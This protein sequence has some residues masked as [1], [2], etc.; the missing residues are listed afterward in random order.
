MSDI[1]LSKAVRT[2]LL[3]LQKTAEM[4]ATTQERLATGNKVN[5]ALD[6]PT[7]F[8]TASSL[9]SRAG[10]LNALM[11]S[12]SNGIKTLEAA[13]NGLTSITKTL[14]AMQSTLRQARQDKSFLTDTY[15]V[16]SDST[17]KVKGG[18]FGAEETEIRLQEPTGG[19]KAKLVT[20]LPSANF[21][22]PPADGNE[23]AGARTLIETSGAGFSSASKL[24][25]DGREITLSTLGAT[26]TASDVATAINTALTSA[27]I[28]GYTTGVTASPDG[29]V[30]VQA[31]DKTVA[32][33]KIE[34]VTGVTLATYGETSFVH[35]PANIGTITV[36]NQTI[37]TGAGTFQEF[38]NS[39]N[40]KAKDGGYE[41]KADPATKRITLVTTQPGGPAPEITGLRENVDAT[42]ASLAFDVNLATVNGTTVFGVAFA[43]APTSV[44]AMASTLNGS[45]DFNTVYEATEDGGRLVITR[46]TPLGE[47]S[48][49][50]LATD[51]GAGLTQ[52]ASTAKAGTDAIS[53]GISVTRTNG[54]PGT[55]LEEVEAASYKMTLTYGTK[56]AE[57]NIVGRDGSPFQ[58]NNQLQLIN[59]QLKAAGM[60]EIVASF[61]ENDQLVFTSSD[62]E[63]KTLA[64]SGQHV[65]LFGED[66]AST[67][68]PA[69]SA[70]KSSNA[71]DQFVEEINRNP[72]TNT[73]IRASNDNGKLR[74][75]NLSTQKLD[76]TFDKDGDGVGA[77]TNHSIGGNSVRASLADE[78]ND[79]KNQLDRLSDDASFNGINLL[80]G[81]NLRITFNE[82]GNSFIE[83]QTPGAD[84][85]NAATLKL[86]H[87]TAIQLDQDLDIDALLAEVKQALNTV[88]TQAS[89]FGSNLSIVQN[90]QDFTKEMINTLQTG[91]AN[92]TLADMNEEAANLLALQTRQSL[93]S[94]SL[95]LA[96]QADQSVLQLL[97]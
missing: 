33:P 60:N 82:S 85:I 47:A 55:Y 26:P 77:A 74:I 64:V 94:S 75:E 30:F 11:D 38:V 28:T 8:F 25:I 89:K 23:G 27:G 42:G 44:S 35:D 5:S 48:P 81:D 71:V 73:Y 19:T 46:K 9:N 24:R 95:S 37:S 87:L 70:Y 56:K 51:G 68:S 22:A 62:P 69:V 12:M 10:D 45:A 34:F 66:T 20:N 41:V 91:A 54:T 50:I 76:V 58:I 4:M 21:A 97:Q 83:I 78:Y 32:S 79:L 6:N 31:T 3:S 14:E 29:R 15:E 43:A 57:I 39:L 13:D 88:R 49:A 92:L 67:G 53:D 59:D 40:E 16:K 72:S 7:N 2:N 63:P 65:A 84:G 18:R 93:S 1:S 61:D 36:G 52:V 86:D 96:S 80:R 90:R 17:L